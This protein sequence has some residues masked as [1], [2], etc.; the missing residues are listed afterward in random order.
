MTSENKTNK[1]WDS[2]KAE[3]LR[4]VEKALSSVKHPRSKEVVEDVGSHLDRR[5]AELEPQQQTWED[6]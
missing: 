3:Y 4:Q 1:T 6:F 5:F 2:V